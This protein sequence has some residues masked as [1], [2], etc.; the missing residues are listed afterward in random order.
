[1]VC[2]FVRKLDQEASATTSYTTDKWRWRYTFSAQDG[3][4]AGSTDE[5][6]ARRS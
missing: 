6:T 4:S 3:R 1:L 5:I 2:L